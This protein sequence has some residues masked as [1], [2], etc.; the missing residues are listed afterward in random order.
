MTKIPVTNGSWRSIQVCSLRNE[1]VAK[2][3]TCATLRPA[4][5]SESLTPK[6][7]TSGGPAKYVVILLLLLG[8]GLGAYLAT[9]GGGRVQTSPARDQITGEIHGAH[10]RYGADPGH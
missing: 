7:P 1:Y 10:Q 3:T 6:P 9:S 5:A 2:D 8:G 4:M